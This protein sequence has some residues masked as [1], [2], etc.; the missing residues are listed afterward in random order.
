MT[1][2]QYKYFPYLDFAKSYT[3]EELFDIIGMKY[4]KEEIPDTVNIGNYILNFTSD[5]LESLKNI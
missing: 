5:E 2:E 3:N 4:N 1:K